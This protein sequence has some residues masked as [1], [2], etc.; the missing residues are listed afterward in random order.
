MIS[1]EIAVNGTLRHQSGTRHGRNDPVPHAL[2]SRYTCDKE[3]SVTMATL[4]A[5]DVKIEVFFREGIVGTVFTH[6]F[7][8]FI[9]RGFQLGIRFA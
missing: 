8:G 5:V 3:M 6:F 2:R 4:A 9:Q 1:V 7:K